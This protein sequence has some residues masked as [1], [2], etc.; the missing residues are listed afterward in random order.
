MSPTNFI[1]DARRGKQIIE[2]ISGL[3]VI[4]Y[5]APGFSVDAS[6]PWYFDALYECGFKYDSSIFRAN[7]AHGGWED[8]DNTDV[9]YGVS[10]KILEIPL[11][12][13]SILGRKV[14]WSGGG[15]FR[16]TPALMHKFLARRTPNTVFYLHPRDLD[17]DQPRL[18]LSTKRSFKYYAGLASAETRLRKFLDGFEFKT[19]RDVWSESLSR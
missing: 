12:A 9:G 10:E 7:R 14:F 17:V 4:G 11:E 8:F 16:I 3:E 6:V 13:A 19:C 1:D 5:R 2:D 18:E 15:Y